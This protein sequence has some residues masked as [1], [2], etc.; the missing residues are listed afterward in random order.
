MVEYA[1]ASGSEKRLYRL[2]LGR[3]SSAANGVFISQYR[4]TPKLA[5]MAG[6]VH[7]PTQA[8]SSKRSYSPAPNTSVKS[9]SGADCTHTV[10]SCKGGSSYQPQ[11]GLSQEFSTRVSKQAFPERQGGSER[12]IF[13]QHAYTSVMTGCRLLSVAV[14]VVLYAVLNMADML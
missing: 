4:T 7:L 9:C 5:I 8:P 2:I 1:T 11:Q 10:R 12:S 13:H 14:L 6:S 3:F